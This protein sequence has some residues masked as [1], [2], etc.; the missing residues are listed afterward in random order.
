MLVHV[1]V[2]ER[3]SFRHSNTGLP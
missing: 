3:S 1:Y 2:I